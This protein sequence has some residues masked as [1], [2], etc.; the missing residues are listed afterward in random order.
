MECNRRTF[1]RQLGLGALGAGMLAHLPSAEIAALPKPI[2]FLPRSTPGNQGTSASQISAFLDAVAESKISFHSLMV[3]RHGHV[4]AEGWWNPYDPTLKHTLYSLSKS[5]TSTAAGLAIEEGLFKLDSPVISFFPDQLPAVV[6]DNLKAMTVRHLL[7]MSTGHAKDTIPD[8]RN[9]GLNNWPKLFLQLPVEHAPG[10][11][12]LYNTGATYMVSAII[13]KTSGQT[14]AAFLKSRLFNPLGITDWDW[15]SDPDGIS[16]GGYGLRV[17]TED[18]AKFGLLYLNGGKWNNQQIVPT[19]WVKAATS[20]Q[21]SNAPLNPTGPLDENDWAQG[22]G[23][24]FWRCTHNAFRGD[25]AFG[26]FCLMLPEQDAVIAITAESFDLQGSLKLVWKHLLPAF[27][28]ADDPANTRGLRTKLSQLQLAAPTGIA[29][30]PPAD[31]TFEFADNALKIKR[32][33]VQTSAKGCSLT[34][35]NANGRFSFKAGWSQWMV[36][37]K[38]KTQ[39]LFPLQRAPVV[40]TPLAATAC[41]KDDS[42]LVITLRYSATAHGDQIT[43]RH[44]ANK[45]IV[46]FLNSVSQGSPTSAEQRPELTGTMV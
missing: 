8:L 45:V 20:A 18:I 12:F 37:E 17:T 26:Q 13:Q 24:Q 10:S 46:Q 7:T 36:T 43:L 11:A 3:V 1:I 31:K 4:I 38:F 16:T 32:L 15:E 30:Q 40:D 42:T 23:Y 19:N 34:V 35:V 28:G 2:G 22:Y 44:D 21:I 5:F 33:R 29:V 9:S 39:Q 27:D 14:L 25:G 41:W 6:S